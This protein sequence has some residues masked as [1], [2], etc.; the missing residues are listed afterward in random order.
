MES[1]SSSAYILKER[2]NEAKS[3]TFKNM[4]SL[5]MLI[6]TTHKRSNAVF[7]PSPSECYAHDD[8]G[9]INSSQKA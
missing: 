3:F 9:I 7:D 4:Q 2:K 6:I 1:F 5:F 8:T